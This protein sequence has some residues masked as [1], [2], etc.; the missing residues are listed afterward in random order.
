MKNALLGLCVLG[1]AY[2]AGLFSQKGDAPAAAGNA[3]LAVGGGIW[4]FKRLN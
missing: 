3:A 1:W 2:N 4:L